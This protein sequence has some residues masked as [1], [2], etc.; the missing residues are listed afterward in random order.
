MIIEGSISVKAALLN[1]KRKVYAIHMIKK[2]GKDFDFILKKAAEK[3]VR[4]DFVSREKL[5]SM[6]TGKT[7][8]GIYAEVSGRMNDRIRS[9]D[10]L[11]LDGIEDPFNV[12]YIMRTAYALGLKNIILSP[13]DYNMLEGQI[14]K[15]SAGAFDMMN[16]KVSTDPVKDIRYL[17]AMGYHAYALYR[18]EGSTDLFDKEFADKAVFVLGG[19]KRGI[20]AE[21]LKVCDEYLHITYASN[22]RNALNACGAADV[23][24]TMLYN[25]RRKLI[26][27]NIAG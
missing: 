11:Y 7:H 21:L 5:E 1:N 14:L 6:V 4:T 3:H 17:K 2:E 8:G 26:A 20:N 23:V 15:S 12:G 19:E 10:V 9:G 16:V 22:F 25:Q 24:I 18:G 27:N 13:R